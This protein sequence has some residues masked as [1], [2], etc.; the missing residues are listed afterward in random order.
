M[1][2]Q[3]ILC[4]LIIS[5][6]LYSQIQ[7]G[8][9]IEGGGGAGFSVDI[10]NN[11][12]RV[13][14][15][16]PYSGPNWFSNDGKAAVY[17]LING[18]W[19]QLGSDL[20][21]TPGSQFGFNVSI[22]GDGNTFAIGSN[23]V[24][25]SGLVK[26][27]EDSV[28][29]LV[30][31][32]EDLT[33]GFIG[34]AVDISDDGN[35][36]AVS[37]QF[38][39]SGLARVYRW[40]NS[41]WT[42]IGDDINDPAAMTGFGI[43]LSNDGNILAV[44]FAR[45]S[46]TGYVRTYSL[47]NDTISPLGNK[48]QKNDQNSGL[49]G[50]SLSFADAGQMLAV[51]NFSAGSASVYQFTNNSWVQIGA[52]IVP[53]YTSLDFGFSVALSALGDIIAIGARRTSG[54]GIESGRTEI[55]YKSILNNSWEFK[56]GINGEFAGDRSGYWVALSNSGDTV[57]I[58]APNHSPDGQARIFNIGM[59]GLTKID[60]TLAVYPNPTKNLISIDLDQPFS[61][62]VFDLRGFLVFSGTSECLIDLSDVSSGSYL[63][64][65]DTPSGTI[66]QII[67]KV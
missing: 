5:L 51:G 9:D 20:I 27:F 47:L 33:G 42:Q 54:S 35:T 14:V 43:E 11:G 6:P 64:L 24:G 48:I 39:G 34:W 49:F 19:S 60:K 29:F 45:P 17:E 38:E 32:G 46:D 7:V 8:Q 44:G 55:Y 1:K 26:V 16:S 57:A 58:G 61:F 62:Q 67:E 12:T 10:S 41:S 53:T 28:G 50:Y 65:L 52:D 66:S 23:Q 25:D 37:S 21:G 59:L 36:L 31:K 30:Q 3:I 15:G 63:L 22:S 40:T 2:Q 4:L 18:T 13:V 56:A